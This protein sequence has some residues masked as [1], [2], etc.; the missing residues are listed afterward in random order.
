MDEVLHMQVCLSL[1]VLC[2]AMLVVSSEVPWGADA[3]PL[4]ER[5][6]PRDR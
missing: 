6:W 3:M 5:R 2:C 1:L 4:A